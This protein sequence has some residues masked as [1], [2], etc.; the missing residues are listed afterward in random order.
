[1]RAKGRARFA[2]DMMVCVWEQA[3]AGLFMLGA[4]QEATSLP[5]QKMS[6]RERGQIGQVRGRRPGHTSVTG[7]SNRFIRV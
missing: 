3:R 7:M 2:L 4:R 6:S 1:M 5:L